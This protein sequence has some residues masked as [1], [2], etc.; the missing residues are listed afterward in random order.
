M[1]NRLPRI[2][3]I[4]IPAFLLIAFLV[5]QI[6]WVNDRLAWR[7]ADLRAGIRAIFVPPEEISFSP[8]GSTPA[9][10][11]VIPS[12]TSTHTALPPTE[13]PPS[14]GT[15]EPT[16]T[17]FP[18]P[19]PLPS[20]SNLQSETFKYYDQHGMYN[21]CAPATLAMGVSYWGWSGSRLEVGDWVKPYRKDLN[22]MPYE[23]E[24][25]AR[26]QAG[27]G[28]ITRVGGSADLLKRLIA[29]GFP[30]LVEKGVYFRDMAGDTTWMGHY[31]FVTGY[32]DAQNSFIA[33]DS[34]LRPGEDVLEPYDSFLSNWR[35]F[36]YTYI[37]LYPLDREADLLSVL[38]GDQ[39]DETANFIWAAE[40]ASEEI[41]SG[42]D[43]VDLFFA[44]YNRGTNLVKL[45]DFSGAAAAYDQAFTIYNSLPEDKSVRP[46][47]I[48]WYQTGPYFAYYY[49]GN[50]YAVI[51]LADNA[52][53]AVYY[54]DT[55]PEES[56]YW[57]GLAKLA[58]G[59]T[60]GAIDDFRMSIDPYHPGF[61]PSLEQLLA[62]GVEP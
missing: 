21:Y 30:V 60:Q 32:D 16:F 15:P 56:L 44:W 47:R 51:D 14:T 2:L 34:Y 38:G 24:E 11:L 13:T 3:I 45:Q 27:L 55:A 43:G 35:A 40:L 31:Q 17:P 5:Y 41:Y 18:T 22:V 9:A 23:M 36:N 6:P 33:Q 42:L 4:G 8:S 50:Y 59:D 20:F 1:K 53:A 28:A 7:V 48:L 12:V 29:S 25:F 26:T 49:T 19:T 37:V 52:L 54:D 61:T 10:T 58:L 39:A 46:Y 57:R 62:L